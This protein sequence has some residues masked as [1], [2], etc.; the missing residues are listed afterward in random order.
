MLPT[1]LSRDEV[2]AVLEQLEGT[3]RLVATLLY[4]SGLRL[5]ECLQLRVKDLDFERRQLVVRQGKG[6]RDRHTPLSR[7][8]RPALERHLERVRETHAS[9]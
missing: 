8:I 4:G 7:R 1:V 2:R 3:Q 6:R 5:L 9:D